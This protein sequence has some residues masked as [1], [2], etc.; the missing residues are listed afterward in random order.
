MS[1]PIGLTLRDAV[2]QVIKEAEEAEK[3][4]P[5]LNEAGEYPPGVI[6]PN[7]RYRPPFLKVLEVCLKKLQRPGDIRFLFKRQTH[8]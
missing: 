6:P 2:K 8:R 3:E 7:I 4:L 1:A 5:Q